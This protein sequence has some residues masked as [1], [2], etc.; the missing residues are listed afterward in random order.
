MV[1][2][3]IGPCF[4]LNFSS[5]GLIITVWLLFRKYCL[6]LDSDELQSFEDAYDYTKRELQQAKCETFLTLEK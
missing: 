4:C 1:H 2:F 3:L 5:Y 6:V